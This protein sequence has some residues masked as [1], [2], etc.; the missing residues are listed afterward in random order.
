MSGRQLGY[1]GFVEDVRRML[2]ET[3]L[4]AS[5]LHL[6]ITE[7]VL[8]ENAE[9]SREILAS[10]RALGVELSID[11]FGT[12]YSSLA[13]LRRFPIETLKID[14]AFLA[15]DADAEDSWAIIRTIR[16]LAH[17]L[18]LGVIVEG[19]ET[20]EHARRLRDLGCQAAQGYL[21]ARPI[22]AEE[23]D[24]YRRSHRTKVVIEDA[25]RADLAT[26]ASETLLATFRGASVLERQVAERQLVRPRVPAADEQAGRSKRSFQIRRSTAARAVMSSTVRC[27]SAPSAS[28]I[29]LSLRAGD[30]TCTSGK[31]HLERA[32]HRSILRVR[33]LAPHVRRHEPTGRQPPP[34]RLVERSRR[35]MRRDLVGPVSVEHDHVP[36]GA[37]LLDELPPV[38]DVHDQISV[39][40]KTQVLP[41]DLE[42][43]R[44]DLDDVDARVG[45]MVAQE[46]RQ[47]AAPETDDQ[48]PLG[49]GP[50]RE[51]RRQPAH[52]LE[53]E[54]VRVPDDDRALIDPVALEPQSPDTLRVLDHE[55]R[56]VGAHPLGHHNLPPRV[57]RPDERAERQTRATSTRVTP[58]LDP[59]V[60]RVNL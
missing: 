48:H 21:F 15:K 28:T 40:A 33:L 46:H 22:A 60:H 20:I 6:E 12:G 37:R 41:R 1:P 49:L 4:P 36:G 50:Q 30:T 26:R 9:A 58:T 17:V 27:S 7:S 45:Q 13:Y 35:Q 2:S 8:M 16:S 42:H 25:F 5:R 14:R 11:D 18:G 44:I 3:G 34:H 57:A 39:L 56:V 23:V 51:R 24:R 55:H 53:D 43:D 19:V 32:Q 59:L 38:R 47:G 54:L 29:R 31:D 52:V 10:L